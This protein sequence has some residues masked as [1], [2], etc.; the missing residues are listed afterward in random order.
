MMSSDKRHPP[1]RYPDR[2]PPVGSI[3]GTQYDNRIILPAGQLFMGDL[4]YARH[5]LYLLI[6]YIAQVIPGIS[7]Q[8]HIKRSDSN[9]PQ[10]PVPEKQDDGRTLRSDTHRALPVHEIPECHRTR[11]RLHIQVTRL[12]PRLHHRF[13]A[14]GIIYHSLQ[15]IVHAVRIMPSP[16]QLVPHPHRQCL[17]IGK[18]P[19]PS[20]R[21]I[22]C[23]HLRQIMEI[24]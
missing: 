22:L 7:G 17:P 11:F 3:I 2:S 4:H 9:L 23:Q 21:G 14:R 15:R 19:P 12:H 20:A 10:V 6:R 5:L 1:G 18:E 8:V 16:G 24:P 13:E